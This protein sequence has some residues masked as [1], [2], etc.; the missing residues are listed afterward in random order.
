MHVCTNLVSVILRKIYIISIYKY[1]HYNLCQ[2]YFEE[3]KNYLYS[4]FV[5]L[6]IFP[7]DI[8]PIVPISVI[9]SILLKSHRLSTIPEYLRIGSKSRKC[10]ETIQ[11][12]QPVQKLR[13][14]DIETTSKRPR[15]ELI[16]IRRNYVDFESR[17]HAKIST[18]NRCHNFHMG[19]P[20]KINVIST[21]FPR[22]ISTSNRGCLHWVVFQ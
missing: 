8:A 9:T 20:F 21:N 15:G 3:D 10:Q 13:R 19:S 22:G 17:I 14:F 16:D 11:W 2:C 5:A 7:K 4:Y 18:S 1:W 12:K 6:Q